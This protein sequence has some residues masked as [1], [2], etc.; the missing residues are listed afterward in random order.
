MEQYLYLQRVGGYC[1]SE[2][3]QRTTVDKLYL[4]NATYNDKPVL[5]CVFKS[6]GPVRS[7]LDCNEHFSIPF[8]GSTSHTMLHPRLKIV[9]EV[10]NNPAYGNLLNW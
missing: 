4:T 3:I 2:L 1:S 10:A 9:E 6:K 7:R 5:M 8:R